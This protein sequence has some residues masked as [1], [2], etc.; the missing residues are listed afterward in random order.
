MVVDRGRRNRYVCSPLRRA[1]LVVCVFLAAAAA[2][3]GATAE[4]PLPGAPRGSGK[5]PTHVSGVLLGSA[6]S[7]SAAIIQQDFYGDLN[8]YLLPA[9]RDCGMVSASDTPYAWLSI[10][11]GGQ[12]LPIATL[13][14]RRNGVRVA[15]ILARGRRRTLLSRGASITFT[16]VDPRIGSVWHAKIAIAS[17]TGQRPRTA[18]KGTLA[19]RWCGRR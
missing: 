9:S 2:G 4:T 10:D 17:P 11:T 12:I 5:E 1:I 15:V 7:A 18:L 3:Q 8:V 14:R 13:L 19:A 6:F 16:R